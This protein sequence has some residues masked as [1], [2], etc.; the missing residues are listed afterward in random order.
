MIL[1][2]SWVFMS[3]GQHCLSSVW[4]YNKHTKL[5]II[6]KLSIYKA[7]H[8]TLSTI[9]P[10]S[11]L[12]TILPAEINILLE[13]WLLLVCFIDVIHNR[14]NLITHFD[15]ITPH[16]NVNHFGCMRKLNTPSESIDFQYCI[17]EEVKSREACWNSP[18]IA[19]WRLRG[20]TLHYL[21]LFFAF[22][23][24]PPNPMLCVL[25]RATFKWFLWSQCDL[26]ACLIAY[27]LSSVCNELVVLSRNLFTWKI[28]FHRKLCWKQ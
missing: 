12:I 7:T 19:S 23:S 2:H 15:K 8:S 5:I 14:F 6:R 10:L 27:R 25:F 18:K 11:R 4:K 20:R 24:D 21:L 13:F 26:V 17:I 22:S 1:L 9:Y 3:S 28:Q 16:N